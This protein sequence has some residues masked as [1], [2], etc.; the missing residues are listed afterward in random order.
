MSTKP[1]LALLE[2]AGIVIG[3]A[4][5][6]ISAKNAT[7]AVARAL[8]IEP[9]QALL[10][11]DRIVYDLSDRPVEWISVQY[12]PDIYQYGVDLERTQ[13]AKGNVWSTS[14]SKR[15][16]KSIPKADCTTVKK[17]ATRNELP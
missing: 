9:G 11:S 7:P 6:V 12:R 17:R 8:H 14:T 2:T 10:I 16:T 4:E 15:A 3:R 5:Q 1:L 13:S